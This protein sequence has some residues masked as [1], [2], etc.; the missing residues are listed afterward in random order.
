MKRGFRV[1]LGHY[2]CCADEVEYGLRGQHW[3][4]E[5]IGAGSSAREDSAEKGRGGD[6]RQRMD[7]MDISVA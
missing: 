4:R 3:W 7:G 1:L 5:G 6:P 2:A